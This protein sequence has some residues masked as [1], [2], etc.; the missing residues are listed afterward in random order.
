MGLYSI[1]TGASLQKRSIKL[2]GHAT[3]VALEA[4]YWQGLE[5]IARQRHLSLNGL[6]NQLDQ[7]KP[8]GNL[9]RKCRFLVLQEAENHL[10]NQAQGW[11]GYA[12]QQGFIWPNAKGALHKLQE[13]IEELQVEMEQTPQNQQAIKDEMGD[14]FFSLF[15]LCHML[16]IDAKD[17]IGHANHKFQR[18]F[19]AMEATAKLNNQSLTDY[20]LEALEKLWQDAKQKEI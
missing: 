5:A 7:Q 8:I 20:N 17:A 14:C 3:S 11:I 15:S 13:E 9:A 1:R 6:L 18:R 4:E 19:Q 2:G 16:K 12:A 10:L